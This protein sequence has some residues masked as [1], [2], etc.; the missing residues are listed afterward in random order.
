MINHSNENT[1][2]DDANSPELDKKQMGLVTEDFLK[3]CD[4]LKE[5]SYQIRSRK[6][7]EYPVFVATIADVPVGNTLFFKDDLGTRYEYKATFLEEFI[8][9]GIVGPESE[10]LFKEHYKNPEEYCC[11][12]VMDGK[13]AGFVYIPFPED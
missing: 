13:F 12:F 11:L 9:R 8:E 1:I 10:G 2:M 6:F 3:V 4:H 7:S 5:G